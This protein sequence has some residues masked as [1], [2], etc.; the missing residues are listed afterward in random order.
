MESF[1]TPEEKLPDWAKQKR[2]DDPPSEV[3]SDLYGAIKKT[4]FILSIALLVFASA[5]NS[6]TWQFERFWGGS[7]NLYQD[8]WSTVHEGWFGGNDFLL[9]TVGV[10]GILTAYF[11][12]NSLF[13]FALDIFQPKVF[14]KY[15]IQDNT[16]L[17]WPEVKK[18]IRVCCR[19]Q[20]ITFLVSIPL[21][22]LSRK[23]GQQ[24]NASDLPS[25]HWV[26]LEMCVFV[27][28]EEIG[29]Y[30]SHRLMHHRAIYKHIHK[31]HHEWTAPISIVGIYCHPIEHFLSN[32]LPLYLGPFIMGSH[33]ATSLLWMCI[34]ISST[35]VSHGGYHLPFFPSPEAHDFHHLKFTNN[36]G[37][38]GVL[39][40][41][42]GTDN[43]FV[44]TKAYD[45]H[46][47]LIGLASA[48]ER[49]PDDE[50]EKKGKSS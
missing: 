17:K 19:N 32:V 7:K 18:A 5:R 43:M 8:I 13:F 16:E 9:A 38:M 14:M 15:K 12:I 4:V 45:R 37:V 2:K 33:V 42:H 10:Y 29:F 30:Y 46:I 11:W 3:K 41:L 40:R 49:F 50:G 36:F 35:Q 22:Y 47:M 34:A 25:F 26:L 23:R 27:M 28:V 48:K 6:L 20:F 24:F 39:D 44:K 31:I 1:S 21:Y